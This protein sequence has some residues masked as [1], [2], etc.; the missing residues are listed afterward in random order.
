MIGV[1]R[2]TV[3]PPSLLSG[4][5]PHAVFPARDGLGRLSEKTVTKQVARCGS[6]PERRSGTDENQQARR[7][8]RHVSGVAAKPAWSLQPVIG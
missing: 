8:S 3:R 4:R 6:R 2:E 7:A 5:C 1:P